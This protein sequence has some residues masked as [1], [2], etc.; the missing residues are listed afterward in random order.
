MFLDKLRKR[1]KEIKEVDTLHIPHIETEIFDI[2]KYENEEEMQTAVYNR[3]QKRMANEYIPTAGTTEVRHDNGDID[4][5]VV[6][7][8]W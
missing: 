5:I 2:S 6:T 8:V 1:E 4:F 7:F 3:I